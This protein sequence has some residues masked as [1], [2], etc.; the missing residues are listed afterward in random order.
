MSSQYFECIERISPCQHI[1]QYPRATSKGEEQRLQ[2]SSK[3]Y[4]PR[5]RQG[6]GGVTI[7]ATPALSCAKELYEPLWD[8]LYEHS[9]QNDSGFRISS[10]W[11][12]DFV[13]Q[14]ASGVLNEDDLGD[15]RKSWPNPPS[16]VL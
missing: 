16:T 3:Q 1:R 4:K 2:L 5:H 8:A 6:D 7:L 10:I 11:A 14:G 9:R 13:N 12:V 15:E